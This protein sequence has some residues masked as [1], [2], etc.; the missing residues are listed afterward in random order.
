[1]GLREDLLNHY[2][3]NEAEFASFCLFPTLND[4]PRL[5]EDLASKI[6]KDRILEAIAHN[7][8]VLIYGDYDCDGIMACSIMAKCF[9]ALGGHASTYIPS[10]YLDGYGLTLDNAEKIAKAGYSLVLLVDNG[11]SCEKEVSYLLSKGIETII[12]DH[13]E[14]PASLPPSLSLI[15][16][17]TSRYGDVPVSAGYLSF[18]FSRFLLEK[19]DPYLLCLGAL[20]TISD[21]M[22]IKAYNRALLRLA[23]SELNSHPHE[24]FSLLSKKRRIDEETLGLEIIPKINAIGRMVE[25]TTINRVVHYFVDAEGEKRQ[26][27][28]L[29]M[30]EINTARKT[31]S[32]QAYEETSFDESLPGVFASTSLMEGLNGLLA[33]RLMQKAH[34]PCVVLSASSSDPGAY[35]GSIRS[36]EG[37]LVPEFFET[38]RKWLLRSG[39]HGHAGGF[40]IAKKDLNG[41]KEAFLDYAAKHPLVP[42]EEEAIPISLSEITFPTYRLVESFGPFGFEWKKPIFALGPLPTSSLQYVSEGKHISTPLGYHVKLLGFHMNQVDIAKRETVSFRGSFALG[43]YRGNDELEFRLVQIIEER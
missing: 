16:P 7:E 13:H 40:S 10:R 37:F 6:A 8:K 31:L 2:G 42:V 11:V 4:L 1:M 15:H 9:I 43:E 34:K 5:D 36:Q 39:G 12:I 20:S 30:E 23:L 28:A 14:L 26:K 32:A 27:L 35:V 25:D 22:P 18:I 29:W 3:L 38:A 41:F 19:D 33:N 24:C 21:L 17:T